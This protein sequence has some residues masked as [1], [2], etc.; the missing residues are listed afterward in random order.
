MTIELN[1]L[2][3]GTITSPK[4]FKAGATYSGI[5]TYAEDKL[6]LG[7]VRSEAPC[8][9]A[10]TFTTNKLRSP[11]VVLNERRVSNG[12]V[13]AIV[14]NSGVANA[15]VGE[16]GMKDAIEMAALAAR[17]FD[18]DPELVLPMSTGMVGVELPM[19]LISSGMEKIEL[20][21]EGGSAMA[22]A[23]RT[24]DTRSKEAA[25]SFS[26]AGS[27][28]TLGGIAKGSGMVHPNMATMLAFLATDAPVESVFLRES[29][30]RAVDSSFNMITID[31][32]TSTNDSVILLANGAAG[33][34]EIARESGEVAD[35]FQ[36]AL[37]EVCTFLA[38]EIVRDGEGASKLIEVVVDGALSDADARVAARAVTSSSLVKSAVHGGDPNWGRIIVALGY[39]GAQVVEERIALYINGVCIM[40]DGRPIPFFKDA[41]VATMSGSEINIRLSLNMGEATATAW[42]CNLSEEYVTFNSAYTT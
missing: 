6:D 20:T 33:G 36:N 11:S 10:G 7:V 16:Q 3:E 35:A 4:G 25:V 26:A 32:D 23:I 13:Q 41:V 28:Y 40:E 17:R 27:A 34:N 19:A 30:K 42:G 22:R 18:L 9:V 2:E 5:R 29:L 8:N 39:S 24:T 15:C 1:W 12:R 14:C 38:K 21:P 37:Q 31:G